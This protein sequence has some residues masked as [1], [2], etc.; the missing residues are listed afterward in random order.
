MSEIDLPALAQPANNHEQ[1]TPLEMQEINMAY[2]AC[3]F[4][5]FHIRL[6]AISFVGYNAGV[7]VSNSTAFLLPSAECDLSMTLVQKGLLNAIPY[8]GTLF[9]T[10]IAGF[11]TD[12]FGR[13]IFVLVG[14]GGMFL[15]MF[16]GGLSQTYEVLLTTKFFEGI[17]FATSF[18][19]SVTLTSE[20]C[21]ND[22]RDRV[23][24]CQSSFSAV[25]QA[26][27]PA[28]AWAILPQDWTYRFFEGKFVLNT[29]NFYL[30]IMSLWSLFTFILYASFIPESPK[31]LLTQKK[32][33]E[34]RSTLVK[35]YK[36]NTRKPAD[37]YPFINI[38][39]DRE[40]KAAKVL[41]EQRV[42]TSFKN[43]IVVGLRNIK[44]MFRK[45][46]L[47]YLILLCISNFL[48]MGLYNVLR[49]WFPQ[50]STIVE[51]YK[52]NGE[53]DLCVM[54]DEYTTDLRIATL[55]RTETD[56]CIPNRSGTETYINS[57]IVGCVC[58][59]PYLV[60]GVLVNKVGK[61]P[62]FFVAGLIC[63]AVTLGLRWANS[64][65][66]IVALFS[67]DVAI[68]QTMLSLNLALVVECFPTTSRTLAISFIMVSG[69]IGTLAGNIM[70]P[71]LLDMGCIIPF[72]TLT[73]VVV[74]V[75]VIS[76]FLPEKK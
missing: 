42:D 63:T 36:L 74:V 54:L 38:W 45:P 49:L 47:I 58:L 70:F 22:I 39:R 1:K 67:S 15:F 13:R 53:Q 56:I 35:M 52:L 50:L 69:R 55:N 26:I 24:L 68:A 9:S 32:Y 18:S 65:E 11:L 48:I 16:I 25:G 6:L 44:P 14:F 17:L 61:K 4:G 72:F 27:V 23:M 40:E 7:L 10:L 46:L 51:H 73:G 64:K 43:Q 33:A 41:P 19:A 28:M 5:L 59:V 12:A 29:W 3:K 62:L 2:K 57:I 60:T 20:F 76:I 71:I 31:Y 37:T 21:H 8:L 34:V 30:M 75:V 66:A